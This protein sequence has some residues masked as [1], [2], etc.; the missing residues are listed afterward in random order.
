M[1]YSFPD[2]QVIPR[3]P[4]WT[5][6]NKRPGAAQHPRLLRQA[7]G[8]Q[9]GAAER[10]A[11]E[12]LTDL[13]RAGTVRVDC[14]AHGWMVGWIYGRR[15]PRLTR[16]PAPTANCLSITDVPPGTYKLVADQSFTGPV[17]QSVTVASGKP[18]T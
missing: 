12:S 14:D 15:R 2:V 8:V 6:I 17:E 5:S 7:H 9:H 18:T 13:P 11:D 16:S 3:G 10:G 4:A 1:P